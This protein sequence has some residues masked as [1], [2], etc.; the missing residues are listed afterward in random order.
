M[1]ES[2][3]GMGAEPSK[4]WRSGSV[5]S[6]FR[7]TRPGPTQ[8]LVRQVETG[9]AIAGS[10]EHHCQNRMAS[11]PARTV[12]SLADSGQS[13][14]STRCR[15]RPAQRRLLHRFRPAE[16]IARVTPTPERGAGA[17]C[18]AGRDRAVRRKSRSR[19]A[20]MIFAFTSP[21]IHRKR[22]GWRRFCR[23]SPL[24]ASR[25]AY[26]VSMAPA[27]HDTS[28]AARWVISLASIPTAPN[29]CG[30][31]RRRY[32]QLAA[33]RI[34]S[35]GSTSSTRTVGSSPGMLRRVLDRLRRAFD[36]VRLFGLPDWH[37]DRMI[38]AQI[39]LYVGLGIVIAPTLWNHWKA[40]H[41]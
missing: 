40:G 25:T 4:G 11:G 30:S 3:L 22:C 21:S 20:Y 10:G 32:N 31:T 19:A 15:S 5:R 35:L 39:V 17:W 23:R 18:R 29:R 41:P 1:L 33:I 2:A 38:A 16:A 26:S 27:V 36:L 24:L 14:R 6:R 34:P 13:R 37:P 28:Y 7:A 12:G 9:L 8:R